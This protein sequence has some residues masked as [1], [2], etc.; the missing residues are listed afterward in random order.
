MKNIVLDVDGVVLN[1][2]ESFTKFLDEKNIKYDSSEWH[3]ISKSNGLSRQEEM[4]LIYNF[5]S[6]S[7]FSNLY[8]MP[9]F[10]EKLKVI[11]D[12]GYRVVYSTTLTSIPAIENRLT[13]LRNLG[14][15]ED[16]GAIIKFEFTAYDKAETV[17]LANAAY[18]IDDKPKN[19]HVVRERCPG[20][21]VIWFNLRG[22]QDWTSMFGNKP[23]TISSWDEIS[24]T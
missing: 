22:M 14:L 6:S 4:D 2:Y 19:I 18:F 13:N 7:Y 12:L 20:T 23:K 16:I 24:I 3:L 8:V 1:F 9:G 17:K 21:E 5:W 11:R 15:L 10:F